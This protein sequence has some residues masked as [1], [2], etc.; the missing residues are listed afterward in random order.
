MTAGKS[1]DDKQDRR[2]KR[3]TAALVGVQLPGGTAAEMTAAL[4]ELGRL[5][6]TL[7]YDVVATVTQKRAKASARTLIGQGKLEIIAKMTGGPGPAEINNARGKKKTQ[8]KDRDKEDDEKDDDDDD[9]LFYDPSAPV[10][11]DGDGDGDGDDEADDE[12][13]A[14]PGAYGWD[15]KTKVEA[16]VFDHE[17]TPTQLRNL[18][19]STGVQV[20]D[21]TGVIVDIFH[22][23]AHTKEARL[24]VEIARLK[25]LAPRLAMMLAERGPRDRQSGGATGRGAG[26]S[27]IEMDRR[28][29]RDRI[30]E[31]NRELEEIGEERAG[32]RERRRDQA[33]VA[34]VGYTNAGKSSLMRALTGSDVYVENKLFATLDTTVRA[35]HPETVPRI[36]VSD[37]V[38]FIDKLPH[39]LVASFRSTLEEAADAS[40]L[41]H[42]VDGS[43]PAFRNQLAVTRTVLG[44]IDV[45][46]TNAMLVLNKADLVPVEAAAALRREFPE[47][48][49]ISTRRPEDVARLRALIL[50]FFD[51]GMETSE[52]TVP[53]AR[54]DVVGEIRR[55]VR[56][57]SETH[58][59][60]GTTFTVRGFP[61]ALARLRKLIAA[62]RT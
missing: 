41:L 37:T 53:Y 2:D 56:V 45:D 13:P 35:M 61:D 15:G 46:T 20:F 59:D 42:V 23:H 54:G 32:R 38:G 21:R 25:Y 51:R 43:D 26:E 12:G 34:L 57:D 19:R 5:V 36:L 7:G 48:V 62:K 27:A 14:T 28:K 11:D 52:L 4:A 22:R 49:L 60:E 39:D 6:D 31:L 50:A 40:L 10:G 47:A 16:V 1:P 24:Q 44:E 58:G 9:V 30:A 17:L 8:R 18:E 55:S 29:I 3:P 33:K